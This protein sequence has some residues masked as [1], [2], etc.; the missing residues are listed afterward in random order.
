MQAVMA[1]AATPLASARRRMFSPGGRSRSTS[2]S[3]KAA[4][5]G[6]LVHV[7]VGRMQ[8][9]AALGHGDHRQ[10]VGHRLGGQRRA[11]QRVERDI[12]LLALAGADLLA[13]EQHRRL[14]ALAFADHHRALHLDAVERA[15]H[16]IDRRLVGLVLLAAAAIGGASDGGGFR[17][18]GNLDRQYPVEHGRQ[19]PDSS[20]RCN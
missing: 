18:P 19:P 1:L 2:P 8:Q 20:T 14:V 7:A 9:A 15:A 4:A 12:D 5:D 3:G 16:G 17:H 11:F 10:R 6:D 13:D